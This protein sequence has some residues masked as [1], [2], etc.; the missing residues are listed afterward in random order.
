QVTPASPPTAPNPNPFVTIITNA[1]PLFNQRVGA[2]SP[3][4]ATN[5]GVLSNGAVNQWNFYVL[6]NPSNF[7]NVAFLTFLPPNLSGTLDVSPNSRRNVEA[8][9]D[10]YVSTDSGLTNLDA[11]VIAAST[12]SRKRG[13]QELVVFTNAAAPVYY[14]GIKSE[15]Q[16]AAEYSF[17]GVVSLTPFSQSDGNGNLILNAVPVG[18]VAI[19]DGSPDKPGGVP[20]I[21]F[22]TTP[23]TVGRVIVTNTFTHERFGDLIGI[24]THEQDFAVLH[25]HSMPESAAFPEGQESGTFTGIYDDSNLND[26]VGSRPSDGPGSLLSFVGKEGVGAWIYTIEDNAINATGRVDA[27]SIFLER[28]L[29]T[30]QLNNGFGFSISPVSIPAGQSR[31][32]SFVVPP[33]AT[34]MIIS[35]APKEGPIDTVVRRGL[36]F[37]TRTAPGGPYVDKG[38]LISPP[39]DSLTVNTSDIP[40]LTPGRYS[41]RL[42]NDGGSAVTVRGFVRFELNLTAASLQTYVS[43]GPTPALDDA[44]TN[45]IIH[46]NRDSRVAGVEVGVHIDHPRVSDLV[47]HLV[48]PSGTRVL[49]A[50][51]RGGITTNGYGY[52]AFTTNTSFATG[53]TELANTNT[54]VTGLNSGIVNINYNFLMVPDS[55]RVYYDT[56]LIFDSGLVSGSGR[57][58]IPFGPGIDTNIVIVVNGD[59][60]RPMSFWNYEVQIVSGALIYATFSENTNLALVPIKFAI[61]PFATNP[62]GSRVT[63]DSSSF[64]SDL[65]GT[66][67]NFVDGWTVTTNSVDV[68]NAAVAHTGTNY[69]DLGIGAI[70]RTLP[71]TQ[72][73]LYNLSF[74]Y[75]SGA[76][77]SFSAANV[78]L[79]GVFTNEFIGVPAW[80]VHSTTFAA[81]ASGTKFDFTGLDPGI[82]FDSFELTEGG[83]RNYFLPEESLNT[84]IGENAKGDWKLEVWDSRAGAFIGGQVLSWQ[85]QLSFASTNAVATTITNGVTVTNTVAGAEIIYFII[86]VPISATRATNVLVSGGGPLNLLYNGSQLPIGNAALGDLTLLSSTFN[87]TNVLTTDAFP[88]LQPGGRY[89]LGVKNVSAAQTNVFTLTVTF[90]E[91]NNLFNVT[92]LQNMVTYGP[93]NLPLNRTIQYYQYD[94]TNAVS[95]IEFKLFNMSGD[96]DLVVRRNALPTQS[97]YDY[98]SSRGGTND[99]VLTVNAPAAGRYYLGVY[100]FFPTNNITYSI[101]VTEGAA[102]STTPTFIGSGTLTTNGFQI[103]ANTIIGRSY[104]FQFSTDL[105]TWTSVPGYPVTAVSAITVFTDPTATSTQPARFY[106]L[107][108]LGTVATTPPTFIG[109]GT[110]TGSGFQI[111]ANTIV[112]RNYR[113]QFST[114]F[115]AWTTV[116]PDPVVAISTTTIFTDPTASQAQTAR[117]YRLILLP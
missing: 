51:N 7:Q 52:S 25:N 26:I 3:L 14:V 64:E 91:T 24:L 2:N 21:S 61:P 56:L 46:V 111:S 92:P 28:A 43:R 45:S 30:N 107:V 36:N 114:D 99:E 39:G 71:T 62:P 31:G 98:T 100:G 105:I 70:S 41:L 33:N 79:D 86:D 40:P 27:L 85:L 93:T 95:S 113:F 37:P 38:K 97:N 17:F 16:Q 11:T 87:G 15:D 77:N 109:S 116:P 55:L 72:S 104:D 50:E 94:L 5:A 48:S 117:F 67:T 54:I 6:N 68:S 66:Y 115:I 42:F 73:K 57:F 8:D 110:L 1:V 9:I 103:S 22:A 81:P 34:N 75:R 47:L 88:Y 35:I 49:L 83:D 58:S 102:V 32:L 89:Y 69:L 63:F 84:F 82:L 4:L 101:L 18:G 53:G 12:K 76:S 96:V 90:D 65:P 20:F 108:L 10:M 19:P 80:I 74:A 106:R 60:N 23:I 112:G 29:E 59:G 78:A 13:G 44:V